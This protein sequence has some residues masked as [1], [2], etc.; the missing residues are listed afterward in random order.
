[1]AAAGLALVLGACAG[2]NKAE[3]NLTQSGFS[4]ETARELS[5]LNLD[6]NEINDLRNAHS[7]GL[8]GTS[9]VEMVKALHGRD[10]KFSIGEEIGLMLRDSMNPTVLTQLVQMGA[11][12]RWADDIRAMKEW[13]ISDVTITEISKLKFEQKKELLSGGEYGLLK[14]HGLSDAGVLEFARKGGT[15]QQLQAIT[16]A[17]DL[18]KPEPEAMKEGG[19]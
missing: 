18:G 3:S 8:D 14:K 16:L 1:M 11:I 19:M 7:A 17:L 10:L 9:A 12:P 2:D 4:P 15:A 6:S 13:K 5:K